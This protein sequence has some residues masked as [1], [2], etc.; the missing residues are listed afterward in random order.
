MAVMVRRAHY[1]P[2]GFQTTGNMHSLCT[3]YFARRYKQRIPTPPLRAWFGENPAC[4]VP[5]LL[6]CEINGYVVTACKIPRTPLPLAAIL[7]PCTSALIPV[8]LGGES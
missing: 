8:I 4:Y 1:S 3:R 5:A 7:P 2:A 6:E